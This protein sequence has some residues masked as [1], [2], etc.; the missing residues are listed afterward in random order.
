VKVS[1]WSNANEMCTVSANLAA[2]SV[3]CAIRSSY[4]IISMENHL[5]NHNLGKAYNGGV[6]ANILDD[7]G[8]NYYDGSGFEGLLRKIYRGDSRPGILKS[9][10]TEIINQHLYY[11]PQSRILH[12]EIFDYELDHCIEPL[13][14]MIE[15]NTD[16]CFIDTASHNNLSTKIILEESDLIVIN[17]CQ[18]S[19][20]LEDFFLNYSSLLSKAVFIISHYKHHSLYTRRQISNQYN[21]SPEIIIPFPDNERYENAYQNGYVHEFISR[22]INCDK[23]NQNYLFAQAVRKASHII[24]RKMESLA[25]QKEIFLCGR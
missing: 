19:S 18:K 11:I 4:S 16:L 24:L 7:V 3:A 21:I 5:C 15:E 13:F 1:F 6:R 2:I 14:Q 17:L 8:T 12:N 10:I 9:Y 22:N 20:V 23:E 25:K